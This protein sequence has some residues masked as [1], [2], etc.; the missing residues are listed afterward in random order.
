MLLSAALTG[1]QAAI[2]APR[3]TVR[4]LML[5]GAETTT[6]TTTLD[7]TTVER[8]E[9]DMKPWGGSCGGWSP[10][11]VCHEEGNEHALMSERKPSW[12]SR[13]GESSTRV[14]Y[15]WRMYIGMSRGSKMAAAGHPDTVTSA[16]LTM[17]HRGK[18]LSSFHIYFFLDFH[19]FY[20]IALSLALNFLYQKIT[21]SLGYSAALP[22]LLISFVGRSGT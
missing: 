7:E 15:Y 12:L 21:R 19:T 17:C 18:L 20:P 9:A 6:T 14:L 8:R 16:S 10:V 5:D 22:A 2:P 3:T 4:P 11:Y 13:W 1:R